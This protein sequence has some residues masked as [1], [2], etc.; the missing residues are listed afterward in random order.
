MKCC[1]DNWNLLKAWKSSFRVPKKFKVTVRDISH[2]K[3]QIR[4]ADN[5]LLF[6]KCRRTRE[7]E[8]QLATLLALV[9]FFFPTTVKGIQTSALIC[10]RI[11][12]KFSYSIAFIRFG[13]AFSLFRWSWSWSILRHKSWTK[14]W[15]VKPRKE[16]SMWASCCSPFRCI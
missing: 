10:F 14:M 2:N 8:I 16:K 11:S 1:D 15:K 3:K 4:L 5:F 6:V 12:I 7:I 9:R 13:C